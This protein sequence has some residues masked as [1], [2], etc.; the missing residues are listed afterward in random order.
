LVLDTLDPGFLDSVSRSGPVVRL[1]FPALVVL[2]LVGSFH[3]L[4]TLLAVGLM[5]LPATAAR[6]WSQNMGT[7][8][9]LAMAIGTASSALGLLLSF[10]SGLPSGPLII[11]VAGGV[12]LLSMI[13]GRAGG[14]WRRRRPASHLEG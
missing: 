7:I 14:I 12:W 5:I 2:N 13:F 11:L 10:A 1:A 8:I 9:A 4:G 3:A 6:L